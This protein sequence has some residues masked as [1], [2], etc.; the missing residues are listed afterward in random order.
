MPSPTT[1]EA[2]PP[3]AETLIGEVEARGTTNVAWART[4]PGEMSSPPE[5]VR[6]PGDELIVMVTAERRPLGPK[7]FVD[8]VLLLRLDAETGALR[9]LKVVEPGARLA[10][11]TQGNIILAWTTRIEK[12][13][14]EGELLWTKTR[15]AE[16]AYEIVNVAV[17]GNDELVLA[18][19]ELDENPGT[20][21]SNPRGFVELEKLD[22]DGNPVWSSRFGDSTSYLQAAWLTVD[23]DDNPVLLAGGLKGAFDFGGGALQGE[24]VVAKYDSSGKHVFSRA[25]GGYGPT[26]YQGTS[27]VLTDSSGNIFVRTESVGEIDIGLGSYFCGRQYVLKLT[28]SGDAVW[29]I[30]TPARELTLLPDGGF[31]ASSDIRRNTTIGERQCTLGD[32]T[33]GVEAVLSRYDADGRLLTTYCTADPGYQEPGPT[34]ADRSDMFF[35]SAVFSVQMGLPDASSVEALDQNHTALVAKVSLPTP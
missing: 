15:E 27:P 29:N 20:I 23:P 30:C 33:S 19:V 12:L 8:D 1:G 14:G 18:R 10:L 11:D 34:A 13:N 22:A 4:L 32:A 16:L 31:V 25:F 28:P 3:T 2:E 35:M 7:R 17:D 24:D 9:W 5:I 26:G 6:G 21:G